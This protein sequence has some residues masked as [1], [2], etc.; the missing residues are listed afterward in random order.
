MKTVILEK[1]GQFSLVDTADPDPPREGEAVVRVGCVGVCGTDLHAFRGLH[2]FFDYPRIAGHELGVEIAELGYNSRGL[3]VG[4]RCAVE[5]Y[6]NCGRCAACRSGR[7]NCCVDLRVL[8][9]HVDGGMRRYLTV[10]V[11]KL[12]KS[13]SLSLDQLA[14]VETLGIGAHA[15]ERAVIEPGESVLVVGAGPIGLGV[16]LF[17]VLRGAKVTVVDVNETRLA[18][19]ARHMNVH[20]CA[21]APPSDLNPS[22]VFDATGD[23]RSMAAS[24]DHPAHGGRLILVG[25]HKGGLEFDA[26]EF[27]K[28]E[29]TLLATRNSTPNTFVKIIALMETGRIDIR[30][31][32]THR[33]AL[34]RVPDEFAQLPDPPG[35][36]KAIIDVD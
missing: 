3:T 30:P 13:D 31:W 26:A 1:P 33:M 8:G 29:M 17:C 14:V 16:V 34:T 15:V 27:H 20:D 9:I 5:P 28:R 19:C 25:M 35:L 24:F 21:A 22:A 23:P 18:F 12:H 6:L 10:P 4:D 7:P 36:I 2:P 32:L 11:S